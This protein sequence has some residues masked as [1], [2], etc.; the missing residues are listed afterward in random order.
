MA[1]LFSPRIYF[2]PGEKLIIQ[3]LNCRNELLGNLILTLLKIIIELL[4]ATAYS[5]F[6]VMHNKVGNI[7]ISINSNVIIS[8]IVTS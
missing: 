7:L 6:S 1:V 8:E 5:M 4:R 3:L 2:Q